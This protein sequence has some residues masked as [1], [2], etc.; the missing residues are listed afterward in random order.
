MEAAEIEPAQAFLEEFLLTETN[1]GFH[2]G[3]LFE[4][5]SVEGSVCFVVVAVG[6]CVYVA[7]DRRH[8]AKLSLHVLQQIVD[9]FGVVS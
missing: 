8:K 6:R 9:R 5:H 7:V 3:Q 1:D 4:G 2:Q